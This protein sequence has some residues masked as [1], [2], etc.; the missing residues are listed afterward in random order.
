MDYPLVLIDDLRC[1]L[2][3]VNASHALVIR[4]LDEAMSWL[5]GL[6]EDD[7][8]RQL[9]LDHDLGEVDGKPEDIMPFINALEE[10]LALGDRAPQID[11]VII[12]TSNASGR[13]RIRAALTGRVRRVDVA[14]DSDYLYYP[15]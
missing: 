6:S 4:T 9:W 8:I 3:T 10:R 11:H 15:H 2:P 13:S 7:T 5:E 14:Q 12:H 1:F